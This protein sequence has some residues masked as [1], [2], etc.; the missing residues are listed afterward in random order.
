MIYLKKFETESNYLA[1]R[2]DK[3]NYLK[4]N[5]SLCEENDIV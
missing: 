3:E 5:I 1:Y 4:P 2:Y